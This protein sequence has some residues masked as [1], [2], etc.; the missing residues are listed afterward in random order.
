ML[1]PFPALNDFARET[2]CAVQLFRENQF[3]VS[4]NGQTIGGSFVEND[5]FP[6]AL[7]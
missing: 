2:N 3:A 7:K 6:P 5:Q 1:A 4:R